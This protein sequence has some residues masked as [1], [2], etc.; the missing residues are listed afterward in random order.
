[1]AG[2]GSRLRYILG[3]QCGMVGK[4]GANLALPRQERECGMR[5]YGAPDSWITRGPEETEEIKYVATAEI[6][7]V[8]YASDEDEAYENV[9]RILTDIGAYVQPHPLGIKIFRAWTGGDE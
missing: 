6:E 7:L 4:C 8:V 1:M 2:T 5:T 3:H 9:E